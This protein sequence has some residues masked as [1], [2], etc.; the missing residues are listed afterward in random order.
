MRRIV[1]RNAIILLLIDWLISLSR[2]A[3]AKVIRF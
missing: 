1:A 3:D 2:E